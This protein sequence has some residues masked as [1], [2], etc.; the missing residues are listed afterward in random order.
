MKTDGKHDAEVLGNTPAIA[1]EAYIVPKV[2]DKW[3]T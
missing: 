3:Q 2:F 1:F